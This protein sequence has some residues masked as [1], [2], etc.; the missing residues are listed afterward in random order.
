MG[1]FKG[2]CN[3]GQKN[4]PPII[5]AGLGLPAIVPPLG[6]AQARRAG[7]CTER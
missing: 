6:G 2:S 1:S 4:S 5:K 7:G 3:R